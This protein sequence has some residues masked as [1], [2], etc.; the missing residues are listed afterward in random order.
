MTN[1]QNQ[2]LNEYAFRWASINEGQ[3]PHGPSSNWVAFRWGEIDPESIV[4]ELLKNE[5][6]TERAV[7]ELLDAR[8][9]EFQIVL[10]KLTG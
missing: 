4:Y 7:R 5:K 3:Q 2:R 6:M 8:I 10:R 9:G 1:A